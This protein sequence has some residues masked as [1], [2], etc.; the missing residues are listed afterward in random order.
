MKHISVF[1]F[2]LTLCGNAIASH[3]SLEKADSNSYEASIE[4][5]QSAIFDD[6]TKQEILPFDSSQSFS[7]KGRNQKLLGY[8]IPVKFNSKSYKNTICRLY[9]IDV[10]N[11]LNF[12]ELFAEKNDEDDIVSSCV[13]IEAVSIH[14]KSIDEAFYLAVVRYRTV[15]SY[16]RAAVVLSY[17][18]GTLFYEKKINGCVNVN[19]KTTNIQSLK[20]KLLSCM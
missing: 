16:G 17:K 10:H 12:A 5:I 15:H 20:K 14:D 8:L 9:F 11:N 13:G 1:F 7:L 4:K 19:G 18:N 6:D 2:I 3:F